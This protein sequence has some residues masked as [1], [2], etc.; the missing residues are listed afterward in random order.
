MSLGGQHTLGAIILGGSEDGVIE[1]LL[2][3]VDEELMQN[4]VHGVGDDE[5]GSNEEDCNST[6]NN[7]NRQES[8]VNLKILEK[9][10]NLQVLQKKKVINAY[11]SD[12][13]LGLFPCFLTKSWFEAMQIWCNQKLADKGEKKVSFEKFMAYVGLEIAMSFISLNDIKEYWSSQMF[14]GQADFK[15]VMSRNE[16]QVIRANVS[17]H[18]PS[19][20]DHKIASEDPLWHSRNLLQHFAKNAAAIAVP[21]GSSALDENTAQTKARTKSQVI[22]AR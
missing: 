11:K 21:L 10:S 19:V 1:E 5:D 2:L 22:H 3:G 17:L 9:S 12:G 18:V 15:N 4:D 8:N 13:E 20:Y 7:V 6:G 16:F 14:L